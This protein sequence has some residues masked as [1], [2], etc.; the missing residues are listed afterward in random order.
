M[1]PDIL[2]FRKLPIQ[3]NPR[4]LFLLGPQKSNVDIQMPLVPWGRLLTHKKSEALATRPGCQSVGSPSP[5]MTLGTF[6]GLWASSGC[7]HPPHSSEF[8]DRGF[9]DGG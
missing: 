4:Y 1:G 5:S 9:Q 3:Q 8:L 6:V 7:P 2:K